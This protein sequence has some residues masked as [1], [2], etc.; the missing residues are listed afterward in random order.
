MT[1]APRKGSVDGLHGLPVIK[2]HVVRVFVDGD[3][4]RGVVSWD[5]DAGWADVLVRGDDGFALTDGE[6]FVTQ[7]V[8]GKITVVAV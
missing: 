1:D 3:M 8:F 5:A 2:G 6:N 7:R 4:P